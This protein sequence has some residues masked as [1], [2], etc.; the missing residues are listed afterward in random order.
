M[1][2]GQDDFVNKYLQKAK[3]EPIIKRLIKFV[4][5]AKKKDFCLQ[6]FN[7]ELIK[8]NSEQLFYENYRYQKQLLG[9]A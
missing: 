2:S 3:K 9:C 8:I 5:L 6:N 4:T 7:K 1:L